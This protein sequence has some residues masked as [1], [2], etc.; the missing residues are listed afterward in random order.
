M[1]VRR[2]DRCRDRIEDRQ[3]V[4]DE[5][6][7]NGEGAVH[8]DVPGEARRMGSAERQCGGLGGQRLKHRPASEEPVDNGHPMGVMTK[9]GADGAPGGDVPRNRNAKGKGGEKVRSGELRDRRLKH[10]PT[11]GEPADNG[12]PMS[13]MAK[14]GAD[15]APG[16]DVPRNR[17]AKGKGGEKVRSGELRDRRLKHRPT[18]GEP[19][20]NGRPMSAMAKNGAD[21]APGGDVPGNRSAKEKGGEKV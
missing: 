17:N 8:A 12:R 3:G 5:L 18:S 21:G 7:E 1:G 13:A 2:C 15:G 11:S 10:R 9:N 20:D 16:G 4:P 6:A 14:N 19:A